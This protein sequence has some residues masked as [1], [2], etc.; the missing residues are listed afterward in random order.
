MKKFLPKTSINPSG[1]TLIELLIVITIIAVLATIGFAVYSGLGTAAKSRNAAR[2]ADL[3][4]ISKALE[5]NFGKTTT[6]NYDALANSQFSNGKI[7]ATGPGKDEV[8]CAND[9]ASTQ[10]ADPTTIPAVGSFWTVC[11]VAAIG[12]ADYATVSIN[13]PASGTKWKICTVLEAEVNPVKVA[14]VFC[15]ISAQ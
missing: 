6:G 12:I 13:D 2:R 9:T 14:S 11:T 5:V 3:D 4:A 1:F 8:Y 7:P 15:K 10:P